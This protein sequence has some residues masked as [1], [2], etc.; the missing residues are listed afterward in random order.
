M[1][2]DGLKVIYLQGFSV[3]L[4]QFSTSLR[5][6]QFIYSTSQGSI[7][8]DFKIQKKLY[9]FVTL[10]TTTRLT[11]WNIYLPGRVSDVTVVDN[12]IIQVE[13]MTWGFLLYPRTAWVSFIFSSSVREWWLSVQT[14]ECSKRASYC[15]RSHC[16]LQHWEAWNYF[17]GSE[18][19]KRI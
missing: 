9:K 8:W 13:G 6:F 19:F 7:F 15:W 2:G 10:F 3:H 11:H 17:Q 4:W 18:I 14:P 1:D 5:H 16:Q 12:K